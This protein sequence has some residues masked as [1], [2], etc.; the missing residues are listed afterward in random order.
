MRLRDGAC[1]RARVRAFA[2]GRLP[3]MPR[4]YVAVFRA[5][6]R[7]CM[8]VLRAFS[9]AC[10]GVSYVLACVLTC[11]RASLNVFIRVS[12]HAQ[13][14]AC[15]RGRIRA[16]VPCRLFFTRALSTFGPFRTGDVRRQL[17]H[18]IVCGV[19]LTDW[20]NGV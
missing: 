7:A 2:R 16:Y 4:A 15:S 20:L 5:F 10:L 14:I 12:V 3:A 18:D 8:A 6:S 17:K 1:V 9:H 11:L 19:D 13:V